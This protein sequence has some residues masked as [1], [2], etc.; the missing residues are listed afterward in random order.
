M[1]VISRFFGIVIRIH[2]R[3]HAPPHFH[4]EYGDQA[5]SIAIHDFAVLEGRLH[6]RVLGLVMEWAALHKAELL[7]DWQR[8]LAGLQ[9]NPIAPLH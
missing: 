4:A 7:V 3:E 9:P 5:A 8:A 6:P 2:F 1:P